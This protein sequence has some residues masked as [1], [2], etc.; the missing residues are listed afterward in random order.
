LDQGK[1]NIGE[2]M[3]MLEFMKGFNEDSTGWSRQSQG[4][5]PTALK[6]GE[7]ATKTNIV[8]NRA[9]MR[10]DLI[11]RNFAEGFVELFRKMLKLTTQHQDKALQ[12]RLGGEWVDMDPREWR[13]QFDVS[14]NVGLGVG[15]KDQ[16]VQHLMALQQTQANGL[17]IG[18]TTPEN[19]YNSSIELAKN[20]GF[21]SGDKFFTKPDPNK[22]MPNPGAQ[23]AQGKMQMKQ[24]ELQANQ[25]MHQ[26]E[27]QHKAQIS[28][29]EMQQEAQLEQMR[30]QMQAQVD[31]NRQRSEAEQ[32]QMRIR[33]EAQL[34]QMKEQL[35][36]ERHAREMQ[37]QQWKT[38]MEIASKERIAQINAES[39]I[40]AAQLAAQATLSA[41]QEEASDA[42]A[43][44]TDE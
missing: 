12:V 4:N 35:A 10:L 26:A 3:Q 20:M 41:Q 42:A 28:Q 21:K 7:T 5:D 19:L 24:M 16:Q 27:L 17:Q 11:A 30:A 2:S 25:Q 43:E 9:D 18:I 39:K 38:Q 29:L 23:E 44:D 22:P 13:N 40:D 31:N 8:T 36:Q 1:G 6:G 34:N 37:F 14:I 33:Q 32:Q 15:S